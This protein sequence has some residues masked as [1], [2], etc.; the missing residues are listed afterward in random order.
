[1]SALSVTQHIIWQNVYYVSWQQPVCAT[2]LELHKGDMIP[3]D[4]EFTTLQLFVKVMKPL[5]D[6]T[7]A[8]GTE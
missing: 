7:E 3:S 5:V 4:V 2:L 6:I 8:I 1:M